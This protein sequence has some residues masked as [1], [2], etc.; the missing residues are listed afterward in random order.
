ML[1]CSRMTAALTQHCASLLLGALPLSSRTSNADAGNLERSGIQHGSSFRPSAG[2]SHAK[3][4]STLLYL[5]SSQRT[6]FSQRL[7]GGAQSFNTTC[8]GCTWFS[9]TSCLQALEHR[10]DCLRLG[11]A[12]AVLPG[13]WVLSPSSPAIGKQWGWEYNLRD[14]DD[15]ASHIHLGGCFQPQCGDAAVRRADQSTHSARILIEISG[16][17]REFSNSSGAAHVSTVISTRLWC[18]WWI[19]QTRCT[20]RLCSLCPST[21]RKPAAHC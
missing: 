11:R 13:I 2:C 12:D 21:S 15:S 1:C 5:T 19:R 14:Y 4:Q 6:S 18:F 7:Y 16:A 9:T 3:Q 10:T 8:T 17:S 20:H